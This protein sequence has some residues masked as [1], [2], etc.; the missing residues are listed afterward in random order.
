LGW[1][2]LREDTKPYLGRSSHYPEG[3]RENGMYCHGVQWMVRAAR[4]LAEQADANKQPAKA[5][6]YREAAYR[7]WM[8][9]APLSH[10]SPTEIELYGGQPNK[11]SADMLS[12]YDQLT[13]IPPPSYPFLQTGTS[14]SREANWGGIYR[15]RGWHGAT[16]GRVWNRIFEP[17]RT[18]MLSQLKFSG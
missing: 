3:V 7:L 2:A 14:R 10:L 12:T 17:S 4:L 13:G 6:S 11:Q 15:H 8:K 9:I 1:P 16:V 5:K 18:E